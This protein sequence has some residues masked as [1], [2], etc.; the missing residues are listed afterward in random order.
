MTDDLLGGR[1]WRVVCG[2]VMG[3]L[4]GMSDNSVHWPQEG[5]TSRYKGVFWYAR[6]KRWAAKIKVTG[7]QI[8]LGYFDD[9]EEAAQT[10]NEAALE[11]FGE[12]ARL[13][14]IRL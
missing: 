5:R 1:R 14:E 2:D 10:Y 11:H 9:E 8:H 7:K 4:G 12:Y 13:N 3:V 6:D